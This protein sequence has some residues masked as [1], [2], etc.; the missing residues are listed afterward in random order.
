MMRS[1]PATATLQPEERTAWARLQRARPNVDWHKASLRSADFLGDGSL[2]R[3][4]V[5]NDEHGTGF[6]GLAHAGREGEHNPAVFEVGEQI[7]LAFEKIERAEDWLYGGVFPL[8]GCRPKRGKTMLR[9]V[10]NGTQVQTLFYWHSDERR[11]A[12]WSSSSQVAAAEPEPWADE[13]LTG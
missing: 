6:V 9:V 3:V 1:K 12:A 5:G 4:M 7:G 10:D 8:E 2:T 11:F 13:S